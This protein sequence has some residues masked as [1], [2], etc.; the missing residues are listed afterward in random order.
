MPINHIYVIFLILATTWANLGMAA[1]EAGN[2]G[3]R[4]HQAA[5][6]PL[7]LREDMTRL[8]AI[9]WRLR[10]AA[11]DLCPAKSAAI[12]L[13]IDHIGAYGERDRPMVSQLLGL[14]QA[15]QVAVVVAGSPGDLAGIRPGDELLAIGGEAVARIAAAG[16]DA[17]LL[18]DAIEKRLAAAPAGMRIDLVIRRK[19]E[20]L[21]FAVE[22]KM[23]CA[24][25]YVLKT[26]SAKHA[27]TDGSEVAIPVALIRFAASDDEL[28]L[29]AGHEL[30]HIVHRDG[31][32]ASL[33][34]RR[35]MEDRADATGA[36]LAHCAGYDVGLA[37]RIWERYARGQLPR[38][39]RKATHRPAA[40]RAAR[41]E[42]LR[43]RLTCPVTLA[44]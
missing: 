23:L 10:Q 26:G 12:G 15:P 3:V 25:R 42:H 4:S 9:E 38:L 20:E 22:P 17:D 32:P 6:W 18:A 13:R 34:Q 16:P 27:Y 36:A 24:T 29:I 19:G 8:G 37:R 43:T 35:D 7:A 33:A 2:A 31:K 11:A 14:S 39:L 28:A 5:P 41:L 30:G 40:G 21:R 1:P 44:S